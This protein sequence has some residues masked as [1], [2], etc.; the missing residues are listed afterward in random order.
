[1]IYAR[2]KFKELKKLYDKKTNTVDLKKA[3]RYIL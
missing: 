1:M 3:K 2:E